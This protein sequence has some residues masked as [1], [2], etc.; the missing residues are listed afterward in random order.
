MSWKF[1]LLWGITSP[2]FMELC[3]KFYFPQ[4][5]HKNYNFIE[6][7]SFWDWL[8]HVNWNFGGILQNCRASR[9]SN[10][11]SRP[12]KRTPAIC[13]TI[14][15]EKSDMDYCK[16]KFVVEFLNRFPSYNIYIWIFSSISKSDFSLVAKKVE[17]IIRITKSSDLCRPPKVLEKADL[18]SRQPLINSKIQVLFWMI[19]H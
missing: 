5:K 14:S 6:N 17:K 12:R 9:S 4:P 11:C 16:R 13:R 18:I 1:Y 8:A 15:I 2:P 7:T 19:L 3:N 10:I